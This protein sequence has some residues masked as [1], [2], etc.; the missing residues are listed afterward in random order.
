MSVP[1]PILAS[2]V[3]VAISNDSGSTFKYVVCKKAWDYAGSAT[4]IEEETDCDVL[5][6]VGAI[7]NVFNFEFVLNTTPNGAT[8]WGSDSIMTFFQNKTS[9][10]VKFTSGSSFYRSI[11]GYISNYTE[12]AA[13]GGMVIGKGT[14]NGSGSLDIT[15]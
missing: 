2:A 14:F 5:T 4:L 10:V 1:T 6:A 3:P 7:K 11:S 15:A 8:E 12:T 9:L 13:Q